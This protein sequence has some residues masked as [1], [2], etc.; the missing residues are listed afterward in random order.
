MTA[1]RKNISSLLTENS[2]SITQLEKQAG[3]SRY[4]VQNIMQGKS[5]KPSVDTVASIAKHFGCT[6]E[7][8]LNDNMPALKEPAI[9][10]ITT[11]EHNLRLNKNSAFDLNLYNKTFNCI[12]NYIEKN[13][14]YLHFWEVLIGIVEIYQY[15]YEN[16]NKA[17]DVRFAEWWLKRNFLNTEC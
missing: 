14:I 5:T 1:L 10:P 2:L 12:N 15:S 3:L 17:L 6:V 11:N 8:L 9:K 7:Q 16:N 13:K 4:S